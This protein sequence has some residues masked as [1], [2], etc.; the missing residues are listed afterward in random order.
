[1]I[2]CNCSINF[3]VS[4]FSEWSIFL[5]EPSWPV[6]FTGQHSIC[7][8]ISV[9]DWSALPAHH[10]TDLAA[11]GSGMEVVAGGLEGDPLHGA[12]N[13]DLSTD[14][15]V[16]RQQ[17]Q[18]LFIRTKSTRTKNNKAY[19]CSPDLSVDWF[20]VENQRC[21]WIC[22]LQIRRWIRLWYQ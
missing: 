7:T 22:L 6:H 4:L 12:L 5:L 19:R 14:V 9:G 13:T 17:Q 15:K 8:Y 11:L 16:T 18:N 1:M 10:G 20:P 3:A 2:F 21:I